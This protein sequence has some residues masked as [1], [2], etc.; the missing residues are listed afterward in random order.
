[1]NETLPGGILSMTGEAADRLLRL[2]DGD[3]ALLY[4]HLLRG[5]Q[6]APLGW[7]QGRRSAAF[8]KLLELGL[9]RAEQEENAIVL[10]EID[11]DKADE[12]RINGPLLRDR[13]PEM[14]TL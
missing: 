11:L 12:A 6:A 4:L 7:D 10:A 13:R 8:R 9:A 3:A 1:M 14:Y 2:G 5:A